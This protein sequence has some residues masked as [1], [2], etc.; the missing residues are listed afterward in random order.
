MFTQKSMQANV[1]FSEK[2]I[3]QFNEIIEKAQDNGAV[4][5]SFRSA[6]EWILD[7]FNQQSSVITGDSM[8]S[9]EVRKMLETQFDE[10]ISND[11][12]ILSLV[13]TANAEPEKE[14]VEVEKQLTELQVI[15]DLSPRQ[16]QWCDDI[17]K[18]RFEKYPD[19]INEL[20]TPGDVMKQL[21]F[22]EK[23]IYANSHGGAFTGF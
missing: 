21:C 23:N 12:A 9:P 17:A 5:N 6:F 4:I 7:N 16:K 18:R 20:E 19:K 3:E 15:V 10:K 1:R 8:I 11:S 13:D 2:S 22:Q 14:T